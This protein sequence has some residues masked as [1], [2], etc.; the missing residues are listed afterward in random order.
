MNER[1]IKEKRYKIQDKR[2]RNLKMI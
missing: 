1:Q 2:Y